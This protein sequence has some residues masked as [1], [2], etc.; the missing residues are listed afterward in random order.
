MN[1][2]AA[3]CGVDRVE[4]YREIIH[5]L[6]EEYHQLYAGQPD[7]KVET[8][9]LCAKEARYDATHAIHQ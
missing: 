1:V 4:R 7:S 5:P 9:V 2:A 6:M 3:D 8:V